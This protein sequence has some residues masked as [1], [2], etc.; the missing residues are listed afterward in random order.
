MMKTLGKYDKAA[1]L[2]L[3]LLCACIITGCARHG[4]ESRFPAESKRE[5]SAAGSHA[6]L[7]IKSSGS[8]ADSTEME[9]ETVE[10]DWSEYFQGLNGTAVVYDASAMRYMVYHPELA[11]TRRSPCSTFKIISSLIALENGILTPE[12][13]T[14]AWS[15]E[16]FWNENWNKDMDLSLIHI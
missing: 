16:V 13:S 9:P 8:P 1:C 2:L 5:T 12:D 10:V 11:E 3:A 4:A 14:R 15:G 6:G 7:K